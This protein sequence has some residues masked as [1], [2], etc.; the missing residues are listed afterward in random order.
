MTILIAEYGINNKNRKIFR[1]NYLFQNLD[2]ILKENKDFIILINGGDEKYIRDYLILLKKSGI[3][4]VYERSEDPFEY[5]INILYYISSNKNIEKII[6]YTDNKINPIIN[7]MIEKTLL[8]E[9]YKYLDLSL[10][11]S[12]EK[13]YNVK[14]LIDKY[15][16]INIKDL[17]NKMNINIDLIE[18]KYN[19]NLKG[20]KNKI[21][22]FFNKINDTLYSWG[23]FYY[24]FSILEKV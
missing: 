21:I 22:D 16:R 13:Y 10:Q 9:F 15:D 23:I 12:E 24:V 6:F 18:I 11:Y 19:N 4:C 17:L 20:I 7:Y 8:R 3:N 2:K 14:L 5:L 1:L